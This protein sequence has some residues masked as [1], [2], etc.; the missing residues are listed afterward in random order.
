ME[1]REEIFELQFLKVVVMGKSINLLFIL[2]LLSGKE[3]KGGP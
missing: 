3:F 2:E 1:K